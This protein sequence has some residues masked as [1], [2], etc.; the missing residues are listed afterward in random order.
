[1]RAKDSNGEVK[2]FGVIELQNQALAASGSWA[3]KV[4]NFHHL[5]DPKTGKP[6][7]KNY[8]TVFVVAASA[9]DA[10][11]WATAFFVKPELAERI[12]FKSMFV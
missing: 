11:V 9:T 3:R 6:I 12:D 7:E 1:M 10:D 5:L 8:G 4:G 2:D